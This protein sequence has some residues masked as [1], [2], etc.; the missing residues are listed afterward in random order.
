MTLRTS[1]SLNLSELTAH[2]S[3]KNMPKQPV[4]RKQLDQWLTRNRIQTALEQRITA[5]GSHLSS[6]VEEIQHICCEPHS[7]M[8][9]KKVVSFFKVMLASMV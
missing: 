8:M 4:L 9:S 5:H 1:I 2:E 3:D 6:L 7:I